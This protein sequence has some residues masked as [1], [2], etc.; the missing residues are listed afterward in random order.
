MANEAESGG[1]ESRTESASGAAPTAHKR[2]RGE[3]FPGARE[4]I[5]QAARTEFAQHG[6]ADATIRGVARAAGVD[7]KLVMHFYTNKDELFA[8]SLE[9]PAEATDALLAALEA[10]LDEVAERLTRAYVGMWES[11]LSAAQVRAMLRSVSTSDEAARVLRSVL[12]RRVSERL[13][14][15]ISAV[16]VVTAMSQLLGASL[17]RYLIGVPTLAELSLEEFVAALVPSV[18]TSLRA[19]VLD[20]G[21]A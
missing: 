17:A 12:E 6:Y 21:P 11:P 2:G 3:R 7:P 1:T 15:R 20:A 5:L 10:P 8:S 18:D 16:A 9:V 14:D 4:A 19:G 13:A